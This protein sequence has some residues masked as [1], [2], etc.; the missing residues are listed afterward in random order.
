VTWRAA[1]LGLACFI[2]VAALG[3]GGPT[4]RAAASQFAEG[5]Q[6]ISNT[7]GL[8]EGEEFVAADPA[9]PLD[10]LA[11]SNEWQPA[12]TTNAGNLSAGTSGVT[13]CALF[14]SHDGGHTWHRQALSAAGLGAFS[15]PQPV[16]GLLP[17][18][19]P[20]QFTDFANL[21][22]ADQNI[23]WDRTGQN[24]YYDC[25]YFG[26]SSH[27]PQVWVFR[28]TDQ[29]RTW[30]PKVVAFDEVNTQVQ[31]DR[32]FLAIDDSGGPRDGTLYLAYETMFY[33]AYLPHV[34]L[35]T[36]ADRGATWSMPPVQVD[37]NTHEA[38]WDP[39][40]FP[41]VGGD[42]VLHVEYDASPFTSPCSCDTSTPAIAMASSA[43]GGK[44]FTHSIVDPAAHRILSQDEAYS[45]FQELVAATAASPADPK[46]VAVAWPDARSGEDRVLLRHSRDG[47]ATWS[48]PID[49]ADDPAGKG[50]QHDHAALAYL[51]DGRLA[52]AWRD[53]RY[54][55]GQLTSPFDVFARF[56]TPT[57]TGY[58][59]SPSVRLTTASQ[60]ETT[61][62]RGNM[63]SEYMSIAGDVSG[64]QASWDQLDAA[65]FLP[66]DVYRHV[67]AAAIPA[68][69]TATST[70]TPNTTGSRAPVPAG[71]V[72]VLVGAAALLAFRRARA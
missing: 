19:V 58:S 62:H 65:Q 48:A 5:V 32:P 20:S 27:D 50:N 67:D 13:D 6:D 10:V 38:Q 72:I 42:G 8:A 54:S 45:F 21:I 37:D 63:P 12:T 7:P 4:A 17:N 35:E 26:A 28:S 11:G 40:Q 1:R 69:A 68:P 70:A 31:I 66:E 53:R 34:W 57:A 9:H 44:T 64:L 59:W 39:R 46:R 2:G 16:A 33:Q 22:S 23:V 49:V 47:G 3:P 52:V 43:D 56:G 55:D 41:V 18:A 24:V 60:P 29:G 36:S 14:D 61:G 30:G 15:I 51:P 71:A 25:I